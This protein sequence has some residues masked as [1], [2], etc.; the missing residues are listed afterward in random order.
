M[1]TVIK[2]DNSSQRPAP[3]KSLVA[4]GVAGGVEAAV[5]YPFEFA[6][7]RLQ[8][9]DK[10][11]V[12]SRNPISLV[13]RV[14]REEGIKTIY[15][16]C[17][18]LVIGCTAKA[19]VR[20]LGFDTLKKMLAD[21]N[22][23]LSGARG[24]LAGLGAG[25]LESVFALTPFETIKTALIDD[26]QRPNPRYHG[27]LHG[28][29]T[30]VKEGGIGAIYKGLVPVTLR[31]SSNAAVRMGS[32]SFLKQKIQ[33]LNHDDPNKPLSGATTFLVGAIA[34]VITVYTTMPL[35]TL[36]TRMQSL[37]SKKEY[38]NTL[39][40]A[41]RLLQEEGIRTFWKGT[42]PRLGRLILSGGIIFTI[43]EQVIAVL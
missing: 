33:A 10:S 7:T 30:L 3:W 23:K 22:G 34:G 4:G 31:Q 20:F 8:L 12:G 37:E 15:T 40:C 36:K 32:Y 27:F 25:V 42:T 41:Q 39:H 24:V 5:T 6:K 43:Y 28:T 21:E 13:L 26:A 16:G 29:Y 19:A 1:T 11:K 17:S 38:R 18:T 14:A 9:V 2:T 35:D